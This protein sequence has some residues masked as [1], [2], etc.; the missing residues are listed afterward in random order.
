MAVKALTIIRWDL[1]KENVTKS[2]KLVTLG[3][4]GYFLNHYW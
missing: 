1:E 2:G 3:A 4:R